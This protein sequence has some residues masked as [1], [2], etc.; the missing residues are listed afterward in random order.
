V[1]VEP[2]AQVVED[3]LAPGFVEDLVV[4]ALIRG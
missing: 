3:G 2:R 1:R 4:Q